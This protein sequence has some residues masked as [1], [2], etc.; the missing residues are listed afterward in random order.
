MSNAFLPRPRAA[1]DIQRQ[2]RIAAYLARSAAADDR[3][4]CS[5]V[6]T[7]VYCRPSCPSR[8]ARLE[9]VRFHDSLAE[10]RRTGFRPCRRC[11]PEDQSLGEQQAALVAQARLLIRE[12][13]GRIST[14]ELADALG[15]SRGHFHKVFRRVTGH[16]PGVFKRQ[17]G[18]FELEAFQ[19]PL[20][21]GQS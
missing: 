14:A 21:T 8:H 20:G 10:A 3:F 19:D 11:R 4:W 17:A 9:H 5:V 6:T 15:V 12:R 16:A 2:E 18:G 13:M 7:A 1:S